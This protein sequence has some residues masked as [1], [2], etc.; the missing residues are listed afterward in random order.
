M[1]LPVV[2]ARLGANGRLLRLMVDGVERTVVGA[3]SK[4]PRPL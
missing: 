4:D 1:F 3:C 2:G